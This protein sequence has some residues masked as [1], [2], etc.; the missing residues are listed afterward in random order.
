VRARS[1][2][3]LQPFLSRKK[4][5]E[6]AGISDVHPE[7]QTS[8][9]SSKENSPPLTYYPIP[10]PYLI[11]KHQ[12]NLPWTI[13]LLFSLSALPSDF[14]F[15]SA[16]HAATRSRAKKPEVMCTGSLLLQKLHMAYPKNTFL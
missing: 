5:R 13:R 10:I 6:T 8:M 3:F 4:V 2:D 11:G 12:K 7:Q 14:S 16:L 9:H 15:Y 1:L